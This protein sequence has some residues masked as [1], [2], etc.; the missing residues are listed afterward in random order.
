MLKL[1]VIIPVYNEK[2][3]LPLILEKVQKTK[4]KE[5]IIV[6]DCSTDGTQD[7]LKNYKAPN[8]KIFRHH[9]N[10]GKGA[11]I[12]TGIKEAGEEII[13]IQDADLEYDPN[14]YERLLQPILEGRADVVYGSRFIG[15][16]P[17]R[18]LFFWHYLG[19]R[20]ITWLTDLVAN[21]NLTDVETGYKIFKKAALDSIR[22]EEKDFGFEPEVTIKLAK[23]K[24]W[25][26]YEVGISY[27]GRS[28]EEGKKIRWTDGLKAIYVILKHGFFS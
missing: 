24:R 8:V 11:A 15:S 19:N 16:E 9:M 27:H 4:P 5:I 20:F 22:L 2:Q 3:T 6:D 10:S 13:L 14:E 21:I 17:H 25:R 26:F 1:S 18:T 28:Y 12:Q 23:Q 7:F